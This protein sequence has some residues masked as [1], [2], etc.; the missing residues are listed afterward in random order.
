MYEGDSI[1][2]DEIEGSYDQGI[3]VS[4]AYKNTFYY[5]DVK[6][7][8]SEFIVQKTTESALM[9]KQVRDRPTEWTEVL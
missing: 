7:T 1:F 2:Y 6:W 5:Y 8:G 4:G 3:L 9:A